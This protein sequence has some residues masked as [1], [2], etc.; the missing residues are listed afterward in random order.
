[1]RILLT[2]VGRRSY[3]VDYFKAALKLGDEVHVA[4]S[5]KLSPAFMIADKAV[6]TPL[7][8]DPEYIPFLMHYCYENKINAIIPLFDIDLPILAANKDNF[9][10]IGVK[11]IVSS[12]DVIDICNDKLRTFNFLVDN[13]FATPKTFIDQK[14]LRFAINNGEVNYPLI[15][16]PRWGMGSIGLYQVDNDEELQ[17]L[18]NKANRDIANTYLKYQNR[19]DL[20][21]SVIIQEKLEGQE[22]GL[23]IINDLN[24]NY[25][26]TVVKIKHA[27]RSGETDCAETCKNAM[28]ENIGEQIAE[29]LKHIANLDVDA[30]IVNEKVYI[31][32]MNARFGGGYPF[33]HQ[34]GVNLPKAIVHWLNNESANP[35]LFKVKTG[36]IFQK[37]IK[38]T[39]IKK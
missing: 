19:I 9:I 23:D 33:T 15:I 17:V 5:T 26:T 6:V 16:K 37:D 1:M 32:E 25:Q 12:I 28:L 38:I 11:V 2:S 10:K 18:I 21:K 39:E 14:E 29:K 31:L 7:I 30:F 3:L 24:G 36:M 13:H 35:S 34:A 8:Y 4:N 20:E 22:Y 27:M